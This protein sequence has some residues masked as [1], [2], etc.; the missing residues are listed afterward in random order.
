MTWS[1][2]YIPVYLTKRVLFFFLIKT[3]KAYISFH[4]SFLYQSNSTANS[5]LLNCLQSPAIWWK[6]SA[7][8]MVAKCCLRWAGEDGSSPR[9]QRRYSAPRDGCHM[10]LSSNAARSGNLN[11]YVKFIFLMLATDSIFETHSQTKYVFDQR[12]PP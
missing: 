12:R 6:Q 4:Q 10:G 5:S 9:G 1:F 11:F 7:G 8:G 2:L 3:I